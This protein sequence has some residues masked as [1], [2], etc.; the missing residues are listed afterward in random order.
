MT[1]E[2]ITRTMLIASGLPKILLYKVVNTS[3][4]INECMIRSLLMKTPCEL[5]KGQKPN[6]T[7]QRLFVV[8]IL[9]IIMQKKL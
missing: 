5:L 3:W 8:T 1:L 9:W 6:M 4:I 7:H 2:E